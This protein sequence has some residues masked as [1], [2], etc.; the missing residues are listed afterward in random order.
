MR[1]VPCANMMC[2]E[3]L[4]EHVKSIVHNARFMFEVWRK[5][6]ESFEH[7]PEWWCLHLVCT[8]RRPIYRIWKDE[9]ASPCL[10]CAAVCI[11][12]AD[13]LAH[14][15]KTCQTT[16]PKVSHSC[17]NCGLKSII[18]TFFRAWRPKAPGIHQSQHVATVAPCGTAQVS[19]RFL[20]TSFLRLCLL[21]RGQWGKKDRTSYGNNHFHEHEGL[22]PMLF[23]QF[24][25]I[26]FDMF[27]NIVMNMHALI[28]ILMS[29]SIS[30][31]KSTTFNPN[32]GFPYAFS[33]NL[34]TFVDMVFTMVGM[35]GMG[36]GAIM[37]AK[38][39][40]AN[41]AMDSTSF[42][43]FAMGF[44]STAHTTSTTTSTTTTTNN[45]WT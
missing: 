17:K 32:D 45:K 7:Y 18:V 26:V 19:T 21:V 25:P 10:N 41:P 3:D 30:C 31:M 1:V 5:H 9:S 34:S 15:I 36:M 38:V 37:H 43:S 4:Q 24:I 23:N 39:A 13:V 2:R 6:W 27:V 12:L 16:P 22:S 29:I 14:L 11:S 35:V 8:R 44:R 20:S 28:M 42:T 40:T 33:T